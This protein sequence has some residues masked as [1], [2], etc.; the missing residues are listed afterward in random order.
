MKGK[1]RDGSDFEYVDCPSGFWLLKDMYIIGERLDSRRGMIADAL[2]RRNERVIL[3]QTQQQIE[4]GVDA[5]EI[6]FSNR[7]DEIEAMTWSIQVIRSCWQI[8]ICLDSLHPKVFEAGLKQAGANSWINSVSFQSDL[9][10]QVITWIS[11]YDSGVIAMTLNGKQRGSTVEERLKLAEELLS[12]FRIRGVPTERILVDFALPPFIVEPQGVWPF[13]E[14]AAIFKKREPNI[15]T[16]LALPNL[17]YKV[18][19]SYQRG[20]LQEFF[21]ALA[22]SAG[23]GAVILNPLQKNLISIARYGIL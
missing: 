7:L 12:F 6:A 1:I 21:L 9:L 2:D 8:P 20:A 22:S 16:L 18:A 19:S 11:Q 23:I 15:K 17:T 14:S 4:A 3:A 10:E 5:I 13:L